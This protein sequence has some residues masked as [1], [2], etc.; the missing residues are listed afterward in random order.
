MKERESPVMINF[1]FDLFLSKMSEKCN[2][3][4]WAKNEMVKQSLLRARLSV[5]LFTV[6]W[7][8]DDDMKERELPVMINFPFNLYYQKWAKN[9]IA[10][11]WAGV[12]I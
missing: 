1:P 7:E 11:K 5:S 2:S 6:F 12:T 8:S 9:E 10:Q 4:K 3:S